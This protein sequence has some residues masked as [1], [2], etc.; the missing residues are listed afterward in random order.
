MKKITV[1]YKNS[2]GCPAGVKTFTGSTLDEAA[3]LAANYQSAHP[4]LVEDGF[5]IKR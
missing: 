2:D 4:E 1:V 5:E 3:V